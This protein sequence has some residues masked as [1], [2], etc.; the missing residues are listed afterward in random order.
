MHL[1]NKVLATE[2]RKRTRIAGREVLKAVRQEA[3]R[4]R[5]GLLKRRGIRLSVSR[6]GVFVRIAGVKSLQP[7]NLF[8][9]VAR[10]HRK[11][12]GGRTS[13]NPFLD[14]ALDRVRPRFQKQMDQA[15]DDTLK[16]TQ[17][18]IAAIRRSAGVGRGR[19]GPDRRQRVLPLRSASTGRVIRIAR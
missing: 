19:R 14:R 16:W 6:K 5:T 2:F 17:R 12:G 18:N 7:T 3:P 1:S 10:G 11:R 9:L 4:G 13:A 15:M 8:Y